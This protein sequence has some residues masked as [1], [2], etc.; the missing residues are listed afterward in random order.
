[1]RLKKGR[2]AFS[3]HSKTAFLNTFW[4]NKGSE[5]NCI[6]VSGKFVSEVGFIPIRNFSGKAKNFECAILG[7]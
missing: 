4:Q 3:S 7:K 2:K 6:R 1:M 5:I